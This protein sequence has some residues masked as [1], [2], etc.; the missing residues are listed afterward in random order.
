MGKILTFML[1]ARLLGLSAISAMTLKGSKLPMKHKFIIPSFIVVVAL[2]AIVF[3]AW[4][5]LRP[6][7]PPGYLGFTLVVSG[8]PRGGQL[9]VGDFSEPLSVWREENGELKVEGLKDGIRHKIRISHQEFEDSIFEV[10][11]E[12]GEVKEITVRPEKKRS[13]P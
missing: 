5:L 6:I 9:F 7:T 1:R 4:L 3:M 12:A 13:A 11:C 8:V 2:A 10:T